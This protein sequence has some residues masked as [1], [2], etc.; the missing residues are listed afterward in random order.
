MSESI[1]IT[2]NVVLYWY[3]LNSTDLYMISVLWLLLGLRIGEYWTSE[4]FLWEPDDHCL[5]RVDTSLLNDRSLPMSQVWSQQTQ[6][7]CTMLDQRAGGLWLV[8]PARDSV[9]MLIHCWASV[10][11]DGQTMSQHWVDDSCLPGARPNQGRYW[12]MDVRFSYNKLNY[13]I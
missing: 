5:W 9:A 3:T 7:I 6:N 8:S 12:Q 13:N 4:R 2:M 1:H 11:D 10:A